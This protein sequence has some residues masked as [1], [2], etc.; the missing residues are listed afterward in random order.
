M[1]SKKVK[2]KR[3]IDLIGV[4][5]GSTVVSVA[6]SKDGYYGLR[7]RNGKREFAIWFLRDGEDN[8]P[9]WFE[10]QEL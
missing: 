7:I 1:P 5:E 2:S 3:L 10:I 6:E 9:G 4:A 8:G